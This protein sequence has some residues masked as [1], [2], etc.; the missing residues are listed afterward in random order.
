MVLYMHTYESY[1]SVPKARSRAGGHYFLS[2]MPVDP[3]K[4]PSNNLPLNGP[5]LNI[6]QIMKNV[7]S[8]AAEAE[9]VACFLGKKKRDSV[10]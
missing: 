2:S 10:T 3:T 4:P 7:M 6:S 5:I 8:S 1:L 9:T